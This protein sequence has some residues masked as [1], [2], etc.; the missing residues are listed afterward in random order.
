MPLWTKIMS[1]EEVIRVLSEPKED[2]ID[3]IFVFISMG[4]W[5]KH[6]KKEHGGSNYEQA[7][8][9]FIN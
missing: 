4:A 3:T 8:G 7:A 2:R 6:H 5:P 1:K 9:K